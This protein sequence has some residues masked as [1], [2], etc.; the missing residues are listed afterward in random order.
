[1]E[2]NRAGDAVGRGTGGL[3]RSWHWNSRLGEGG[4]WGVGRR[5]GGVSFGRRARGGGGRGIR[6]Q[7]RGGWL[8]GAWGRVRTCFFP[9]WCRQPL[10][11]HDLGVFTYASLGLALSFPEC[12]SSLRAFLD[13][14]SLELKALE[15]TSVPPASWRQEGGGRRP[16]QEEPHGFSGRGPQPSERVP[17][18]SSPP[19][20]IPLGCHLPED[21]FPPLSLFSPRGGPRHPAAPCVWSPVPSLRSATPVPG[22]L[23]LLPVPDISDSQ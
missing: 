18:P 2:K 13:F 6:W 10:E 15:L 4:I 8:C 23:P 5:R 3:R 21:P 16:F 20:A 1:M 11:C 9:E 17:E 22:F 19:H 14:R 12:V 7:Q